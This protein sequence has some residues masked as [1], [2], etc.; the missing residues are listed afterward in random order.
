LH[1]PY[2]DILSWCKTNPRSTTQHSP[3]WGGW[4]DSWSEH[5]LPASVPKVPWEG[6]Q[7]QDDLSWWRE[8]KVIQKDLT[9]QDYRSDPFHENHILHA[10][11]FGGCWLFFFF[12]VGIGFLLPARQTD[13]FLILNN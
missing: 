4:C 7:A 2:W 11:G 5:P 3:T 10:A 9:F 8:G 6:N 1:T 13:L 12:N